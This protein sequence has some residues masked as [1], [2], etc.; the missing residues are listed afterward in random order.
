[1]YWRG[2]EWRL[3]HGPGMK[4]MSDCTTAGHGQEQNSKHTGNSTGETD[5][6]YDPHT[7]QVIDQARGKRERGPTA[8][9]WL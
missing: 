2:A 8:S 3:I 4:E 6:I 9:L 1:M 5:S 7:S